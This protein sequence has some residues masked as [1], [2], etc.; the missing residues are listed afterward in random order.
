M[1]HLEISMME[2]AKELEFERAALL[3]DLIKDIKTGKMKIENLKES[4]S[5]DQFKTKKKGKKVQQDSQDY[6]GFQIMGTIEHVS[7]RDFDRVKPK[8]KTTKK[9][10]KRRT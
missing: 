9:R 3:R 1:Q 5:N 8:K 4:I 2:A 10:K 7:K 6:S